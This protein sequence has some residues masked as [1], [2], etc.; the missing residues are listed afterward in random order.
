MKRR[1]PLTGAQ[2]LLIG[3]SRID[4]SGEFL[5]ALPALLAGEIDWS[6]FIRTAESEGVTPLVYR[7]LKRFSGFL[8]P[9]VFDAFRKTFF[10]NELRNIRLF[11]KITPLLEGIRA[12]G[13]RV[14]VTKGAR[15]AVTVYPDIGLRGFTDVDL[16]VHPRDWPELRNI[17]A[18][19][20]FESR[21][22]PPAMLDKVDRSLHWTY[23]PYYQSDGLV[24]ELH[25]TCLGLHIPSLAEDAF[26]A[27]QQ[28]V[29]LGDAEARVLSPEYEICYLCLHAQQHS[30]GRLMWLVDIAELASR[31]G[32]DGR[33]LGEICRAEG[34]S[35]MV[36]HTLSIVENLW[37]GT[38]PKD[39][40][41]NI[42][43]AFIE[44]RMLRLL[45]PSAKEASRKGKFLYPYYTPTL[46]SLLARRQPAAAVRTLLG[47]LFPPR[48][49]IAESYGVRPNSPRIVWHYARR[50]FGPPA[51]YM[52]HLLRGRR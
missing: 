11:Q 51:I 23:S 24:V 34:L 52:K 22:S 36:R 9:A 37:P 32:V 18:A 42:P 31:G 20:G 6:E 43:D 25:F 38:V 49:W 17:L 26:W 41:G 28:T 35:A 48:S 15:L 16:F 10:S 5:S 12:S 27:S 8:P 46:F 33:R 30:F 2:R 19:C 13:L 1:S 40:R 7:N 47:I 4:P 14:A 50:I 45:W 39:I 21:S 44:G 29:R 3:I